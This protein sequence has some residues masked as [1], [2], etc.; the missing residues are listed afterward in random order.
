[1]IQIGD[2]DYRFLSRGYLLNENSIDAILGEKGKRKQDKATRYLE[3]RKKKYEIEANVES[4]RTRLNNDNEINKGTLQTLQSEKLSIENEKTNQISN[5]NQL[6]NS[7]S[8]IDKI[9]F[10]NKS[11][12]EILSQINRINDLIGKTSN[13]K[14]SSNLHLSKTEKFAKL[15]KQYLVDL[16]EKCMDMLDWHEA[17]D[18]HTPR[19]L[20]E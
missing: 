6:K 1:M 7:I 15:S 4:L 11:R 9:T 16:D 12:G 2:I 17:K 19:P 10:K 5:I 20:C 3:L 13:S 8:D 18:G 14:I